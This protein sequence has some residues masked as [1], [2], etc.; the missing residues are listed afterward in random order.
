MHALC[1]QAHILYAMHEMCLVSL[2]L[3]RGDPERRDGYLMGQ[4]PSQ[5]TRT[6][7]WVLGCAAH[8]TNIC[9]L[10]RN[11]K[12]LLAVLQGNSDFSSSESPV[13]LLGVCYRN[14]EGSN[15]SG[16]LDQQVSIALV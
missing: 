13:W 11:T 12:H 9:H 10:T 3:L 1:I 2:K 16:G 6:S 5:N 14:A 7:V 8:V 15:G 4:Q